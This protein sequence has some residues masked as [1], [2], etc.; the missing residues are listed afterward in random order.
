ME[1]HP[2]IDPLANCEAHVSATF[3]VLHLPRA[4]FRSQVLQGLKALF[5]VYTVF[6]RVGPFAKG[7]LEGDVSLGRLHPS[8]VAGEEAKPSRRKRTQEHTG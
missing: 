8:L 6:V 1:I 3:A 5:G 7:I 2:G 4:R